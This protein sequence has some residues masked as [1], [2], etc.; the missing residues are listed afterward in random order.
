MSDVSPAVSVVVLGYNGLQYVDACLDSLRD[1][2]ADTP[3]YEVL[4]FD[5]AST[6]GTPEAVAG[7]HRWVRLVR[8]ERNLGYAAGNGG[9]P[10]FHRS[11]S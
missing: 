9:T 10:P 8:S 4:F 1:Q 2:D 6:D 3:P 5:N 11:L 7:R